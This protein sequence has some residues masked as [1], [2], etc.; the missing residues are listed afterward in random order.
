MREKKRF[1]TLLKKP[2][3]VGFGG[4]SVES[5]GKLKK[6][7][8]G[9]KR[10]KNRR[11]VLVEPDKGVLGPEMMLSFAGDAISWKKPFQSAQI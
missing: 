4:K 9:I 11:Y 5:G 2:N 3:S 6:R 10:S 8:Y 7:F 1:G